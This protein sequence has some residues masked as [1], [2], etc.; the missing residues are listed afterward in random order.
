MSAT[1]TFKD[2]EGGRV[3]MT[4]REVTHLAEILL[5]L[6]GNRRG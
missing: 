6:E 2:R 5:V 1:G 3:L 4:L